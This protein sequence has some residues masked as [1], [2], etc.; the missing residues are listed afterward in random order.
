MT[1]A[2]IVNVVLVC[3]FAVFN[4]RYMKSAAEQAKAA[5]EQAAGALANTVGH[6]VTITGTFRAEKRGETAEYSPENAE[7]G[8]ILVANLKMV[9]DS[10]K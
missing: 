2:S 7:T 5:H 9:S 10:C 8:Q 4:C 3:V 1:F 6:R